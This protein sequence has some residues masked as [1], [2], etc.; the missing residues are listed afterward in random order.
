MPPTKSRKISYEIRELFLFCFTMYTIREHFHNWNIRWARSK[1]TKSLIFS[2][3]EAM[4]LL[5][6]HESWRVIKFFF[7]LNVLCISC[8]TPKSNTSFIFMI[9]YSWWKVEP[10]HVDINNG[11]NFFSKY[12]STFL[13]CPHQ[14]TK[15]KT[16]SNTAELYSEAGRDSIFPYIYSMKKSKFA[17]WIVHVSL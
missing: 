11:D 17:L 1:R 8:S 15:T 6:W 5:F 4:K 2:K 13:W 12:I 14:G 7:D 16:I 9:R 3:I 10:N